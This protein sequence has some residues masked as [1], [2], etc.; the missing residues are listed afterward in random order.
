VNIVTLVADNQAM[1]T[2]SLGHARPSEADRGVDPEI[3]RHVPLFREFDDEQLALLARLF[4]VHHYRKHETIFREGDP[5]EKFYVIISGSVA[6]VRVNADGRETILSLLRPNDFFG[7]M[8]IFDTAVRS[9]SVRTVSPSGVAHIEREDFLSLLE[10]TPR[11]GRM[12]VVALAERLRSANALIASAT[13]RDIRARLA[14]LLLSLAERFGEATEDG[15]RISVRLTNQEMANMIGTTRETVNR[16]LNRLWDEHVIDMRTS[17][18]V[19]LQRERLQAL[20]S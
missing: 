9:A 17:R 20:V 12:L 15:T 13:T 6:V 3:L 4:T 14:T 5:G 19:I 11:M 2:D 7:E 18:V 8:S 10:R 16:T 1:V